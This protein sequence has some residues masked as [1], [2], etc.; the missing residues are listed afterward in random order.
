M[1]KRD[2]ITVLQYHR[3]AQMFARTIH[4]KSHC[5]P[6]RFTQTHFNDIHT[7]QISYSP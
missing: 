1:Q 2:Q 7:L 4:E 5:N 6:A 3:A